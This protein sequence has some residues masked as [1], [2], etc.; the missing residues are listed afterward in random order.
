MQRFPEIVQ[1]SLWSELVFETRQS[2]F[3]RR[4]ACMLVQ[5]ADKRG[6]GQSRLSVQMKS[7]CVPTKRVWADLRGGRGRI[8][9][10]IFLS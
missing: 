7:L 9:S 2:E 3:Q 1:L 5:T 8:F 4:P 10:S 6:L